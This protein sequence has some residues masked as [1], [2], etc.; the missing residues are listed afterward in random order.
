MKTLFLVLAACSSVSSLAADT[1]GYS[2]DFSNRQEK[3][4]TVGRGSTYVKDG[5][6]CSR[7]SYA[8]FGNPEWRNYEMT[9]RARAPKDAEQVQI[10][11]GFRTHNRFDRYVVGIK[12]GL[13]DDIYL[14]RTG[15]M[16]MDEFMGVRPLGFHPVQGEWY[17]LRVQI[18][19][20]R[21]RVFVGDNKK[22][23]ID[24]EDKNEALVPTGEVSLGGGWIDTE[25][26]DL[27]VVPLAENALKGVKRD[28]LNFLLTAEQKEAKRKKERA[29]YTAK[30][31][32]T[33]NAAGNRTELS[34]DGDWLFMPEYEMKDK[35]KAIVADTDDN[36][37][38]VMQVPNFWTPIRIWLHG[39]TMPA[40]VARNT[41]VC[42]ILTISG[43][44]TA[45]RTIPSTT[46]AP[47]GHGIASG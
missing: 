28:E 41:R 29:A 42:Q 20:G 18:V 37:W 27:T 26:D 2:N 9:F 31:I 17:K 3:L 19:G 33:L 11:A 45:V 16:G 40:A 43:R 24:I 15:H 32:E 14:M 30:R 44:P 22:P 46:A 47:V 6:L 23:H 5:V 13:Q 12:G 38:H 36:T 25:F 39:E 21:I 8:K 7:G 4:V 34:L 1:K 10:W 35:A